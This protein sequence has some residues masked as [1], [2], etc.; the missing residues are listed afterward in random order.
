MSTAQKIFNSLNLHLPE[1][2]VQY[3]W[4]LWNED[5]FNFLITKSRSTKLGDFRYRKD[6]PIQTITINSDLNTF[7]FLITYIHE[8]AH[9]R[10]FKNYGIAIKPHGLEWKKTF[11]EIISPMLSDLVFPKDILIPLKRHMLNPKAST[12]A[13]L[14]LNR[15][16]K[17]YNLQNQEPGHSLLNDIKLGSIFE[18]KGRKFQ[19][20][21]VRRT[22][23][24]C[25]EIPSGKKYLISAHA[26]VRKIEA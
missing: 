21:T 6:R 17:K 1:N 10:A 15:E 20:E 7:Q 2:S 8:V 19:K 23:V 16:I 4:D 9:H 5:P 22:R 26:E 12:G 11:Q 13:D 18:L 14:F 3:C 24:L 25:I